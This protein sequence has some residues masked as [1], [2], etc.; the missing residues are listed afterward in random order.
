MNTRER[1]K[2]KRTKRQACGYTEDRP[3]TCSGCANF[4]NGIVFPRA[5]ALRLPPLC[6]LHEFE[7]VRHG[8]CN[9]YKP[10]RALKGRE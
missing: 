2:A 7:V 9:D 4:R 3:E 8:F 1:K 6:A 5:E 10:Q